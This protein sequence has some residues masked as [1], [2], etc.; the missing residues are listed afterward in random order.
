V[1]S[2]AASGDPDSAFVNFNESTPTAH[3][4]KLTGTVEQYNGHGQVLQ[5]SDPYGVRSCTIFRNDI[6]A[7]VAQVSNAKTGECIFTNYE[8]NG[9][10]QTSGPSAGYCSLTTV[11]ANLHFAPKTLV[12]NTAPTGDQWVRTPLTDSTKTAGSLAGKV[13]RWEFWAKGSTNTASIA[14]IESPS[15]WLTSIPFNVSTSWQKYSFTYQIPAGVTQYRLSMRPPYNGSQFTPGAIYYDDI[16]AYPNSAMMTTMYYNDLWRIP[17]LSVDANNNPSKL[18]I[19][20][21]YGRPFIKY[22]INSTMNQSDAGYAT[23]VEQKEY[24]LMHP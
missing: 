23:L 3:N 14:V 4:W 15:A 21:Q 6:G 13:I 16:R 17:V 9:M 11:S 18:T 19:L 8:I 22:K 20:D 1:V 7:P 2:K 12:C 5:T 10:L 24:Q